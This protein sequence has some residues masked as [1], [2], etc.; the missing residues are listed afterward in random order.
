[1]K[2]IGQSEKYKKLQRELSQGW[3]T[4]DTCSATTY[5]KLPEAFALKL[6]LKEYQKGHLLKSPLLAGIPDADDYTIIPGAHAYDG[7][8]T[9]F[10]ISW[11]GIT[12]DI[13]TASIDDDYV[14]LVK[15]ISNQLKSA[16]LIVE[17][18]ILW[19]RKGELSR[20]NDHLSGRFPEGD[21]C[22]YST[23][24]PIDDIWAD[25]STPFLMLP[26]DSIF[27][28]ST[29]VKRNIAQI[30]D[31]VSSEKQAF[32]GKNK[33]L[34][35]LG[36]SYSAMHNC[37][38]WN[39]IYD[40][41]NQRVISPVSRRWNMNNG[42]FALFC[43]DTYFAAFIASFENKNI[44]Y[45]NILAITNDASTGTFVPNCSN[46]AYSTK[47]RSQP[48]IGSIIL[49]LIFN[50]F[51]EKWIPE[52]A[53]D[54]LLSWNKWWLDQRMTEGLLCWGS[55][56]YEPVVGNPW[57]SKGVNERF[58]GALESGLDNSPMYDDVPF[59]KKSNH[60][61]M[62]DVGLNALY[63]A[64]CE[65]LANIADQLQRESDARELRERAELFRSRIQE[66]WND[67]FGMFL[68]R[69][70]DT[71]E[72]SQRISPSN[73]YVLLGNI[74]TSEQAERMISEHL[75]NPDEFWGEWV[76]PSVPRNDPAY[77][78][79]DYWRGRIW[80]PMNFLVY[81]G[82][83]NYDFPDVCVDLA[84]KSNQLFLKEWL[85]KGHVHE[86]YCAE[87]GEGCNRNNSDCFYH[88]GGLLAAIIL[89]EQ[90]FYK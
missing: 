65:A 15:P 72:F 6:G 69:R 37:L 36:E 73:F 68:N 60:L 55:N 28:I 51:K 13:E 40:P 75:M 20:V 58:G 78:D 70:T 83:K 16:S 85:E 50:K 38:A 42:G 22:V 80:A 12:L 10:Q 64:D 45:V 26:T 9:Q 49:E 77:H 19:N 32:E 48:P 86:N 54:S 74:A 17:A 44:A 67:D 7:S 25:C 23:V 43:W 29:G 27:G 52:E 34:K 33:K 53:Y 46:G 4:W 57:E 14:V 30:N 62:H 66:L 11:R 8:Y 84:N 2:T 41:V 47:D 5:V 63:V 3:N 24:N 76:L 87:T 90:E 81:L 61:Q 56:H 1:M 82:L 31:I 21:I 59:D 79:Q 39:T 35:N 88:W 71:G 18:A 89:M